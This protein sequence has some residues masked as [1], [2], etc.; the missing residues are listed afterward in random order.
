[1]RD[2]LILAVFALFV[3]VIAIEPKR[4][5]ATIASRLYTGDLLPGQFSCQEI[6]ELLQEAVWISGKKEVKLSVSEADGKSGLI[7]VICVGITYQVRITPRGDDSSMLSVT[8]RYFPFSFLQIVLWPIES[9]QYLQE[10]DRIRCRIR[11]WADPSCTKQSSQCYDS[12]STMYLLRYCAI[13]LATAFVCYMAS[14]VVLGQ[15]LGEDPVQQIDVLCMSIAAILFICFRVALSP[16]IIKTRSEKLLD[17]VPVPQCLSNDELMDLLRDNLRIRT[18]QNLYFD[19]NGSVTIKGKYSTYVVKIASDCM[20]L[21]VVAQ[22]SKAE[23]YQEADYIQCSIV[24]LF[25]SA[26]PENPE[27]ARKTLTIIRRGRIMARISALALI[28]LL[29]APF[30]L[31]QFGSKG[32]ANSYLTQYSETVTVGDAF[33]AFFANPKWESYKIG[34]QEYVDFTGKCTYLNEEA[35][36]RITFS[37]FDDRFNVSNI[38]VNGIDMPALLW[39][40]FLEVVYLGAED[41]PSDTTVPSRGENTTDIPR[42]ETSF[43][44]E[45]EPSQTSPSQAGAFDPFVGTWQ[46]ED[47]YGEYLFIGYVDGSK[48][49]AYALVSTAAADFEVELTSVTDE[50]ASGY[51]TYG[52]SEP[53][54]AIDVTRYKYWLETE[55]YYGEYG[56]SDYIKFVPAD[57]AT[58]PYTNPYYTG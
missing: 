9:N 30:L 6:A 42:T 43:T 24:K 29:A 56:F 39:P 25:N 3:Y 57:P 13:A 10:A 54:Y 22:G 36:M 34:G 4:V 18:M 33:G 55:I 19:E 44:T 27:K 1:M 8:A 26:Y 41:V 17:G 47:S 52:G 58:C 37:V 2:I 46:A 32:I 51:E 45:P 14:L 28:V 31:N 11:E 16:Y 23:A 48:S 7:E 21:F 15:I 12:F 35:V 50:S 49:R 20:R 40:V 5:A 38:A 53:F